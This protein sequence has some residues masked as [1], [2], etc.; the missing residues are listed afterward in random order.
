MGNQMKKSEDSVRWWK[1]LSQ[2]DARQKTE[3]GLM[4]FR[5]TSENCPDNFVTWFR[6]VFF[7]ELEWRN[8]IQKGSCL[9]E[10]DIS[11]SVEIMGENL[12]QKVM[13][14]THDEDRHQNHGAPTTHLNF[15]SETARYLQDHNMAGRCIIFSRDLTGNFE[16]VIQD[17]TPQ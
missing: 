1:R 3:G 16:L 8:T 4:P 14:L 6:N 9:Q 2:S 15:D 11:M 10:S 5:F 13:R 17:D 12:G 7:S